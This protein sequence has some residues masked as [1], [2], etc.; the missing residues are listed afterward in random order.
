MSPNAD[1]V[2]SRSDPTLSKDF[3]VVNSSMSESPRL[4][5]EPTQT[6]THRGISKVGFVDGTD[7]RGG[8]DQGR[9]VTSDPPSDLRRVH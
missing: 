3:R 8:I 6:A 7:E 2:W 4:G 9:R 1:T 5:Y